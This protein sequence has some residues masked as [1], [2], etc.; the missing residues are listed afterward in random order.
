MTAAF[1]PP[2]IAPDQPRPIPIN[3]VL[4]LILTL[5][6]CGAWSVVW[7]AIAIIN[8]GKHKQNVVAYNRA[9]AEY[10]HHYQQWAWAQNQ[11]PNGV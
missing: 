11:R 9:M 4:H 1:G 3:H 5:L 10:T 7:I 2:P 8:E 6:T